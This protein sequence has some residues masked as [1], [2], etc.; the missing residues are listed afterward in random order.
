MSIPRVH[1][2]LVHKKAAF[3]DQAQMIRPI[4]DVLGAAQIQLSLTLVH[5]QSL[6]STQGEAQPE[7]EQSDLITNSIELFNQADDE[8][9]KM[10]SSLYKLSSLLES[11]EEAL[12]ENYQDQISACLEDVLDEQTIGGLKSNCL[13]LKELTS[14]I[15]SSWV[16]LI[17]EASME[18][19]SMPKT[20]DSAYSK[21]MQ[22]RASKLE[23]RWSDA[24]EQAN[25]YG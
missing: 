13:Q 2:P 15:D 19:Q 22:S 21:E 3:E 16:G 4:Q 20:L 6:R 9:L 5:A 12:P 14:E 11:P 17:E 10:R 23:S 7:S 25:R 8:L 18:I 24:I 1:I